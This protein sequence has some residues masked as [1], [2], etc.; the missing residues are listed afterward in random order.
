MFGRFKIQQG[1]L[2]DNSWQNAAPVM[3]QSLKGKT[4]ISWSQNFT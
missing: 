4:M 1:K 2:L 3:P